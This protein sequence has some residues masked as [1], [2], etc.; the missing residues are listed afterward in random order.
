MA[1]GSDGTA[2]R[3]MNVFFWRLL[4]MRGGVHGVR[5]A[6]GVGEAGMVFFAFLPYAFLLLAW[7]W[8]ELAEMRGPA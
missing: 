8:R 5:A 4:V 7:E 3:T 1:E 2:M 6:A